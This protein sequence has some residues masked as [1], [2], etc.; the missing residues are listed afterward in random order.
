M[1]NT[2]GLANLPRLHTNKCW[3]GSTE[4]GPGYRSAPGSCINAPATCPCCALCWQQHLCVAVPR[5]LI[6]SWPEGVCMSCSRNSGNGREACNTCCH[7]H[8][9][10]VPPME[11]A[12]KNKTA[13]ALGRG[14]EA[15]L[16]KHVSLVKQCEGEPRK[17]ACWSISA[18]FSEE[19]YKR[20]LLK[21]EVSREEYLP[22]LALLPFLWI[23]WATSSLWQHN[24]WGLCKP[25]MLLEELQA[26]LWMH[27]L[28]VG[29][30]P[31]PAQV[32]EKKLNQICH[33]I[34]AASSLAVR[35]CGESRLG[36][37][38]TDVSAGPLQ[39]LPQW[40]CGLFQ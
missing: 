5:Q 19:C 21:A 24:L 23:H 27:R 9:V 34:N 26:L 32:G 12:W 36:L 33:C 14:R 30:G 6:S 37:T 18:V 10:S 29:G 22:F 39:A 28:Q 17:H 15:E 7:Q 35:G 40:R 2:Q 13:Y 1:E 16:K 11:A 20:Q 3:Q 38:N 4:L 8:F 25:S 31:C